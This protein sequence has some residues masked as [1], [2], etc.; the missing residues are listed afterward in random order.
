MNECDYIY[1]ILHDVMQVAIIFHP[2]IELT[3]ASQSQ[4]V[5]I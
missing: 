5:L 3:A 1:D 2:A 4:R